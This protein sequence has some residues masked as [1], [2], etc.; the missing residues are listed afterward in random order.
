MLI[1]GFRSLLIIQSV[2]K[3]GKDAYKESGLSPYTVRMNIGTAQ[4]LNSI[5]LKNIYNRLTKID[6]I[7]KRGQIDPSLALMMFIQSL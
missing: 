3:A 4:K 2:L 6:G 1:Y 7:L 5:K